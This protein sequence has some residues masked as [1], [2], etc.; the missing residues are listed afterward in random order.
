[1]EDSIRRK[2]DKFERQQAF[3]TENA[4]D[5]PTGTPAGDVAAAN[6]AIVGEMNSLAGD[7]FSGFSSAQQATADKD[8][9]FDDLMLILKN[10]NRAANAFEDA[11]PGTD[12]MFRLP[13]NRSE[14]N[15]LAAARSFQTDATP[16]ADQFI[17]YGL[18]VH[19]L[20]RLQN[21]IT[22]IES[23]GQRGDS[24]TENRAASTA[25]LMDAA[26]RGMKNSNRADAIV[27]IKYASNPQ[28][29]AAWTVASHLEHAPKKKEEPAPTV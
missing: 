21:L 18:D 23:A 13:R 5:F 4:A 12:Q 16:L 20:A 7:Q 28:K 9:L 24:G 14:S 15:L 25:G 19:F 29:L 6:A 8:D 27:R 3:F 11:I 22:D 26:R 17:A 10:M 1:M 2:L